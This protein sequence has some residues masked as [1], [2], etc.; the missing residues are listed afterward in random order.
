MKMRRYQKQLLRFN[1]LY[2]VLL[3]QT[4][5]QD[6][7]SQQTKPSKRAGCSFRH[8]LFA[9]ITNLYIPST[10]NTQIN[11]VLMLSLGWLGR[12]GSAEN[13]CDFAKVSNF[14]TWAYHVFIRVPKKIS[15]HFSIRTKKLI[16]MKERKLSILALKW[17]SN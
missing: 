17:I 6:E 9:F 12:L 13:F 7:S 14:S 8:R 15:V 1:H 3:W 10:I 11:S 16:H 2:L 4:E 5:V